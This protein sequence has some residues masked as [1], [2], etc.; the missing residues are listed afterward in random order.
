MDSFMLTLNQSIGSIPHP[1]LNSYTPRC[2]F[3]DERPEKVLQVAETSAL[4]HL[5][6][7][8]RVAILARAGYR[9]P[10]FS[11]MCGFALLSRP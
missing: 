1:W 3:G 4:L 5:D 11:R 2:L 7:E 8:V 10:F 9:I 6:E